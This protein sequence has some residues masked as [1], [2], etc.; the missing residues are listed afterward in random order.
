MLRI[1]ATVGFG[2]CNLLPLFP[3]FL[4]RY[5][6][7]ELDIS[8]T[9]GVIGRVKDRTDIAIR[10]GSMSVSCL[11]ARKLLG[12][13]SLNE[14]PFI[15]P[16]A[17]DSYRVP[18]SGNTAVKSGMAMRQLCPAGSGL[19]RV[20]RFHVQPDSDAG[21]PVPVLEDHNLGDIE[22]IRKTGSTFLR[23]IR[24]REIGVVIGRNP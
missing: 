17:M 18:V 22:T 6:E 8:L 23:S 21:R 13:R 14:W 5:P 7:F 9:D 1:N 24:A 10:S 11:K 20:G 2:E 19:G 4:P 15:D 3:A 12:S 16:K